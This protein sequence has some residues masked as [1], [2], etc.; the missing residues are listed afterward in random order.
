M[1]DPTPTKRTEAEAREAVV[2]QMTR[3]H[4]FACAAI[5]TFR[6]KYIL[7]GK[8][9][10]CGAAEKPVAALDTYAEAVRVAERERLAEGATVAW[11][12]ELARAIYPDGQYTNWGPPRVSLDKPCVPEGSIRRLRRLVA[13]D[14][15]PEGNADVLRLLTESRSGAAADA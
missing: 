4:A 9:C 8:A 11:S 12:Y 14:A 6:H 3:A 15:A 2:S 10:D 1:P 13:V 5:F 7:S